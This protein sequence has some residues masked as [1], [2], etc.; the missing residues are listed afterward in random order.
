MGYILGS[1]TK[2]VERG[3]GADAAILKPLCNSLHRRLPRFSFDMMRVR[4]ISNVEL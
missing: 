2:N 4:D 1:K 3:G